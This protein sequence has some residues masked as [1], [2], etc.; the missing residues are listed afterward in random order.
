MNKLSSVLILII[1]VITGFYFYSQNT[2]E[3]PINQGENLLI[4]D[5]SATSTQETMIVGGDKDEHGCIG[6]AG[7][8]W[9]ESKQACLRSWEPE[10]DDSCDTNL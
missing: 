10:W 7:Y 6:S 4:M 5:D 3:A 1:I 8:R 2:A 9:C